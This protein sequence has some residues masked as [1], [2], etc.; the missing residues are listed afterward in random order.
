MR[1]SGERERLSNLNIEI[2]QND[3]ARY[4]LLFT[5]FAT[6]S[7]SLKHTISKKR[8]TRKEEGQRREEGTKIHTLRS[9][10][11]CISYSGRKVLSITMKYISCLTGSREQI[12]FLPSL[13]HLLFTRS[14][15]FLFALF[16]SLLILVSALSLLSSLLL[17]HY[18][19]TK[20]Y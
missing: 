8:Q 11:S 17:P 3:V 15:P 6:H 7:R 18:K 16:L 13:C 1:V 20:C 10:L 5:C 9:Y 19:M 4:F 2:F 14:S 12:V